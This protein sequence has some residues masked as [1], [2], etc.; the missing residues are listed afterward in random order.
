MKNTIWYF[1][2]LMSTMFSETLLFENFNSGSLP[3]GWSFTPNPSDY[4]SNTGTWQIN[5]W[6]TD[7]NNSAPAAT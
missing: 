6:N 4:P 1:I 3:S 7:Y 5:N 2:F